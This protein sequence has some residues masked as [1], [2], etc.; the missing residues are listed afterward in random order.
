MSQ[1]LRARTEVAL[2][3]AAVLIAHDATA[4]AVEALDVLG[5]RLVCDL[6]GRPEG[7]LPSEDTRTIV[8]TLVRNRPAVEARVAEVTA[9]PW[10]QFS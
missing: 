2:R 4:D 5:W 1:E 3:L 8:A 7:Y 10:G 9:D 6:A